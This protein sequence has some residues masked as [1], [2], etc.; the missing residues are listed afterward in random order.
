MS[1]AWP[2]SAPSI[3]VRRQRAVGSSLNLNQYSLRPGVVLDSRNDFKPAVAVQI[4]ESDPH[5]KM[6]LA[7]DASIEAGGTIPE[8]RVLAAGD[9]FGSAVTVEVANRQ[10][11]QR[12]GSWGRVENQE[13]PVATSRQVRSTVPRPAGR[14]RSAACRVGLAPWPETARWSE[15]PRTPQ[16]RW[17]PVSRNPVVMT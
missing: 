14:L 4:F 6:A 3:V 16:G 13:L 5:L 12:P 10:T 15:A 9:D 2:G 8:Q 11:V 7:D 1:C 17:L